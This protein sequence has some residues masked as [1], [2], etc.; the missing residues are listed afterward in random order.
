MRGKFWY[1][2]SGILLRQT[3]QFCNIFGSRLCLWVG[4]LCPKR[5]QYFLF[6]FNQFVLLWEVN[7]KIREMCIDLNC[8]WIEWFSCLGLYKVSFL[9]PE[10][11][12][13]KGYTVLWQMYVTGR[14]KHTLSHKDQHKKLSRSSPARPSVRLFKRSLEA[15]NLKP[16][17]F[18]KDGTVNVDVF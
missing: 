5:K 14:V 2:V 9:Y 17:A 16:W 8:Y 12:P 6:Q 18:H 3:H 11:N 13:Q 4:F 10:P 1:I 7:L 15:W